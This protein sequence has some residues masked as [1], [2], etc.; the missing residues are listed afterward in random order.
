MQGNSPVTNTSNDSSSPNTTQPFSS[1]YLESKVKQVGPHVYELDIPKDIDE[2]EFIVFG[3]QGSGKDSQKQT[4]KLMDEVA[5][6]SNIQC[7]F[8]AGDN[9]YDW[10]ATTPYD[11]VFNSYFHDIYNHP[12]LKTLKE[13]KFFMALGNHDGN[14]QNAANAAYYR[15]TNPT[16]EKTEIR[17]VEHSYIDNPEERAALYSN[18]KIDPKKLPQWNMPY[19]F[20]SVILGDTQVFILDSSTYAKEY[21]NSLNGKINPDKVNQAQW[22][23]EEYKIAKASGRKI[24]VL[25][26]HPFYTSGKRAFPS[27]FDSSHYLYPKEI[28]EINEITHSNTK[29]YNQLLKNIFDKQ[30][31]HFDVVF[32]AHDHFLSYYNDKAVAKEQGLVQITAGGGGGKLQDRKSYAGHPYVEFL[33]QNGFWKVTHNKK[34]NELFFEMYTTDGHHLKFSDKNHLPIRTPSKDQQYE[35]LRKCVLFSC[36]Q[37]LNKLKMAEIINK[38]S[39]ETTNPGMLYGIFNQTTHLFN[40]SVNVVTSAVKHF[41]PADYFTQEITTL[42]QLKAYFNHVESSSYLDAL[43]VTEKYLRNIIL[44]TPLDNSFYFMLKESIEKEMKIPVNEL[45]KTIKT[46]NTT[47]EFN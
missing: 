39:K 33:E 14:F 23:E 16:G 2:V 42:H 20:E 34:T 31:I 4:A 11:P 7:I 25:M 46:F 43:S 37:Y 8:G 47:A 5:S 30:D 22:L 45:F 44:E 28:D 17:E 10:G 32:A 21:L 24:A 27:D 26:H 12:E 1:D 3:C 29:S 40:K 13:K 36:D 15:Y 38:K 41:M 19:Y 6:K 18:T 9:V 35:L